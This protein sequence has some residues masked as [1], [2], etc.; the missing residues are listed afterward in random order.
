MSDLFEQL[1]KKRGIGEEFLRPDYERLPSPWLLPDMEKA[2]E[3]IKRGIKNKDKIIIYGDYDADGVTA[4]TVMKDALVLAG[5]KNVETMLPDRFKDGYGMSKKVIRCAKEVGAS[6]VITVDCGSSNSEVVRL[7]NEEGVDT[8]ITDHHEC[9]DELPDAIAIVNPKRKDVRDSVKGIND[10]TVLGSLQNLAGVGVAFMVARA[11]MVE[12]MIPPG[13]EK[14]FLDLVL[15][16]TICDSMQMRG[17]NRALCFYGMK[18]IKKTRR[19]GLKELMRV[20][21]TNKINSD[22]IGFQIGPRLNAAGRM[23]SAEVALRLLQTSSRSEGAKL[24]AELEK[25]NQERRSQQIR[26]MAEFREQGLSGDDVLVLEGKWH[27]GVLGIIAGKLVEEYRRPAFVL[28]ETDDGVLKGSGRS[29]GDFNLAEALEACKGYLIG[30]GGHAGAAG[31][32]VSRDKLEDFKNGINAYYASLGLGNQDR[33]FEIKPDLEIEGLGGFTLDFLDE[34]RQLEP[35]G[36]GN[37]TPVFGL[38]DVLVLDNKLM[39]ANGQHLRL[40][41]RGNDSKTMKLVAFNAPD[42]WKRL[43]S[44]EPVNALIQVDENEWNGLRSIEGRILDLRGC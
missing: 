36:V 17:A 5:A 31:L 2:I 30:G 9:P 3:R 4:S 28:T 40:I 37:E 14:W 11:M 39:G 19:V 10:E 20:A 22:A 35:F 26:A 23:A 42:T 29:F 33:F 25:Y 21:S 16:G 18:V 32:K 7:L 1:I 43:T 41:V 38:K 12:G 24:A 44:G 8:V 34:L 6:L 27:E 15:I 13:Q